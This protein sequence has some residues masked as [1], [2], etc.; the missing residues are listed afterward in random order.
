MEREPHYGDDGFWVA[1]IVLFILL[2]VWVGPLHYWP[3]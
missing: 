1:V 2:I 3:L